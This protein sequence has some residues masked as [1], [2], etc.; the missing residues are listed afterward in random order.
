VGSLVDHR[1]SDQTVAA[2]ELVSA[3]APAGISL[4]S[5]CG[6]CV[7]SRLANPAPESPTMSRTTGDV[8]AAADRTS[9]GNSLSSI[10]QP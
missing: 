10:S 3:A 1:L 5:V 8:V 7:S 6:R 2:S 4:H 9:F